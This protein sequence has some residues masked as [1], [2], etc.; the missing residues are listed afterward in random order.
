MP[1]ARKD[2]KLRN[3]S[4]FETLQNRIDKRREYGGERKNGENRSKKPKIYP[5]F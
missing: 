1:H 2:E 4:N 5:Q 3:S